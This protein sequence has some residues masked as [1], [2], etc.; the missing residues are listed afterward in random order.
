MDS[1]PANE[2]HGMDNRSVRELMQKR[3]LINNIRDMTVREIVTFDRSKKATQIIIEY[4]KREHIAFNIDV[5][6]RFTES[7]NYQ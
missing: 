7:Y 2:V 3:F 5:V 4:E 1:L 6:L